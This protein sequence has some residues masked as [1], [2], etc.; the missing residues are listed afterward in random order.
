MLCAAADDIT[1]RMKKI[2]WQPD[3]A[4]VLTSGTM[5]VGSDFRRFKTQVGLKKEH[6]VME[7]VSPSPFDY[8]NNC[9]LYLPQIPPRQRVEDTDVYF[10]ELTPSSSDSSKQPPVTRW[11]SLH[12][13]QPCRL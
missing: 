4:F 2:L 6:R 1:Q 10:N 7:S 13:T 11:C 12:P 5:A 9:L 8:R 3:Q